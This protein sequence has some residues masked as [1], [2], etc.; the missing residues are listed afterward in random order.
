MRKKCLIPILLSIFTSYLLFPN[1]N[2][3]IV[4]LNTQI[5]EVIELMGE[6]K[7]IKIEEYPLT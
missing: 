6:P 7:E 4:S 1:E 5:S 3:I 2:K